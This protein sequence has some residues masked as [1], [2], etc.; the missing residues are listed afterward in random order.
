MTRLRLIYN[1]INSLKHKKSILFNYIHNQNIDCCM[2]VETKTKPTEMT[3]FHNWQYIQKHGNIQDKARGGSLVLMS[4]ALEL[5]KAN[6]PA[7]NNPLNECLHFTIP[8]QQD[9]IHIFLIYIHPFSDIEETIFTKACLYKYAIIIGDFNINKKKN[10]QLKNFLDNSDFHKTET[11]PTFLMTHN[12]DSTPDLL[13]HTKNL[14][15][16]INDVD[17]TNELGSDHLAITFSLDLHTTPKTIIHPKLNLNKTPKQEIEKE[18]N[19]F[20]NNFPNATIEDIQEQMTKLIKQTTPTFRPNRF[21]HTL[22]KFILRLIKHKRNLYRIY[23]EQQSNDLKITINKL[24]KNIHKLIWEFKQDK[25]TKICQEINEDKGRTYWTK[26]K[27]LTRYKRLEPIGHI[28]TAD[29]TLTTTTDKLDAFAQYYQTCFEISKNAK[30]CNDNWTTVNTWYNDHFRN[31]NYRNI[32]KIYITET[33]YYNALND[34]KNTA[35]GG[36]NI[37]S[38]LLKHLDKFTHRHIIDSLNNLINENRLPQNWKNGIIVPIPKSGKNND[39]LQNYRPITLLPVLSKLFEHI[40]KTRLKDITDKHVPKFQFGFKP[41]Q[42]TIHPL[43][44]LTNNIQTAHLKNEHSAALFM[45]IN[46]AFDSVWHAGLLYKLHKLKTPDYLLH[47]IKNLIT[48]RTLQ[49]RLNDTLSSSFPQEQGLPQG[50]PLSPI[51][52]NIYCHDIYQQDHTNPDYIDLSSYILQYADDTVLVTHDKNR[53]KTINKLQQLLDTTMKWFYKWR[54]TPNPKKNQLLLPYHR[55]QNNS[56]TVTTDG[57]T[58]RPTRTVKYLGIILDDKL[59][60]HDHI[61]DRKTEIIRRTKHFRGL[62]FKNHGINT[63]TASHIYKTICRPILEYGHAILANT[64]QKT[65]Q[66]LQ[67][68]ERIALRL[69]TKIRHPK[70]PLHNPPNQQLYNDTKITALLDRLDDLQNKFKTNPS[71]RKLITELCITRPKNHK[72]QYRHPTMTLTEYFGFNS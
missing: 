28:N 19:K 35:P 10:K 52:Y 68:T 32:D 14:D 58:T 70:N 42:S 45:D 38:S 64:Q 24:N 65:R 6:P 1:N 40:V 71:N 33:E 63:K 60:F 23:R 11:S 29:K 9:K 22:P 47:I 21:T 44:I 56:P 46:K 67:T 69:I 72:S 62:T 59:K 25:W 54:L 7:I 31:D 20:S 50:S 3:D 57:N 51:L 18:M 4:P 43:F 55:V 5:G 53:H 39:E 2:L 41:K 37:T 16:I 8:F 15:N 66:K 36:D 34:L 48:D 26:I 30:F 49:I 13:L 12:R 17:L 27:K 61:Q